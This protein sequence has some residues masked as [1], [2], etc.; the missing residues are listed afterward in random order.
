[1]RRTTTT[2]FRPNYLQ[3]TFPIPN[4]AKSGAAMT[5]CPYDKGTLPRG[6]KRA[7]VLGKGIVEEGV[8]F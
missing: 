7:I 4:L 5:V 6:H 8:A 2:H 3:L 1:M